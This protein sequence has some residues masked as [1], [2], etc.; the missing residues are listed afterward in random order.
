MG[1]GHQ[2][3]FCEPS[4]ASCPR[5]GIRGMEPS[6]RR[7]GS[8]GPAW[9]K[10]GGSV[11]RLPHPAPRHPHASPTLLHPLHCALLWAEPAAPLP[12]AVELHGGSLHL[13]QCRH[14]GPHAEV[15][16]QNQRSRGILG[17]G[18][19]ALCRVSRRL[20]KPCSR[21]L[22]EFLPATSWERRRLLCEALRSPRA[23]A[24]VPRKILKPPPKIPEPEL[25]QRWSGTTS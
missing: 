20:L 23:R 1:T 19:P 18:S 21:V 11:A 14:L 5:A 22:R 6:G 16:S 24:F 15:C 13:A 12:P 8:A 4:C 10:E 17:W 25:P 3:S 2:V 7:V 9:L